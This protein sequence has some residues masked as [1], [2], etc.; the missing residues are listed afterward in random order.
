MER[1]VLESLIR[2]LAETGEVQF[3]LHHG[4][5]TTQLTAEPAHRVSFGRRFATV[6]ADGW[7]YHLNLEAIRA[8]A[9][10]EQADF[11]VPVSYSLRFLD[12]AGESLLHA[13]FPS[14]YLEGEERTEYTPERL[15]VW[16]AQRVKWAEQDAMLAVTVTATGPTSASDRAAFDALLARLL[17]DALAQPRASLEVA[18]GTSVARVGGSRTALA[19]AVAADRLSVQCR[20]AAIEAGLRHVDYVRFVSVDGADAAATGLVDRTLRFCD[21]AGR[22]LLRAALSDGGAFDALLA[23]YGGQPGVQTMRVEALTRGAAQRPPAA[24]EPVPV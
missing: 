10:V 13:Y 12:A 8:V 4:G 15:E 7:H 23:R 22:A 14:P 17:P 18:V 19:V 6:E 24:R 21:S 3:S 1:A 2:P 20:S 11:C 9:F 5:S 16:Q